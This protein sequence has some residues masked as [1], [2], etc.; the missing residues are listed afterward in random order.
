[1]P[2][3]L[4]VVGA[5]AGGVKAL[6]AL[7]RHLPATLRAAVCVVLHVPAWRKSALPEILARAG[8]LP[9]AHAVDR[10]LIKPGR[11][12]VA[13]PDLHMLINVDRIELWR[14]PRENLHRPAVNPLF[15]SAATA[16][17][18]RVAA[19][20]LSGAQDD[21]AAGLWWIKKYGGTTMAQDPFE[22]E[23]PS[24]PQSA[25]EAVSVDHVAPVAELARVLTWLA[26]G[27]RTVSPRSTEG[28]S[29]HG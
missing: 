24:M 3:D 5:S 21:G 25:I 11:V 2:C 20:V 18:D 22:A 7:V 9:A 28:W 16:Y 23:H 10:E 12:Y 14:G 8:N 19:V 15:R 1:M 13:P 29:E 6:E 4:V 17:G 26:A 27:I